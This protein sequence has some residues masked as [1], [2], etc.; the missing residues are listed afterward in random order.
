MI[1]N[2]I[3]MRNEPDMYFQKYVNI[4]SSWPVLNFPFNTFL[5]VREKKNTSQSS[6][7][8]CKPQ[9]I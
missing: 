1:T 9:Y 8:K 6:F 7:G 2:F 4:I 3:M 5:L